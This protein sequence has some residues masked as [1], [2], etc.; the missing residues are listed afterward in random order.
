MHCIYR[1]RKYTHT[2]EAHCFLFS[3]EYDPEKWACKDKVQ[4]WAPEGR[5]LGGGPED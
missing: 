4:K 3:E 2:F 1:H 5:S